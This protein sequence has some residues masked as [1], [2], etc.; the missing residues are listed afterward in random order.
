MMW[1]SIA[2]TAVGFAKGYVEGSINKAQVAAN[3]RLS[4]AE[5]YQT[6]R[7]RTAGNAFSAAKGALARY[8][9]SVNNNEALEAG[10]A[11]LEANLVNARRQDDAL[12]KASF[13][14]QIRAAEQVGSQAAA[15]AF[16]GAGG[17]V[18][19]TISVSTRLM[20]QRA[21]ADAMQARDHRLYDSARRASAIHEQTVRSL[22]SS[23]IF[24]SVDYATNVGQKTSA[25][26]PWIQAIDGGWNALTGSGGGLWKSGGGAVSS[27]QAAFS[28]TNVGS[29]GWGTGLSYGNQDYGNYI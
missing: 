19:D 12:A 22:D 11:A 18:A 7:I 6:N 2:Q 20:R 28:Q 17:E 9:Q 3:N 1:M 4:H 24:D 5:A 26:S 8:M 27:T 14:D 15:A 16:T 13:E 25:P 23:L 29:S 10:G 21:E